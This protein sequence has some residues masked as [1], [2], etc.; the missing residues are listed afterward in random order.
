M[1]LAHGELAHK[2]A[3]NI[4]DTLA[5]THRG[6]PTTGHEHKNP[7]PYLLVYGRGFPT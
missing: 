6:V 7:L 5:Y 4:S 2:W 3:K 1:F